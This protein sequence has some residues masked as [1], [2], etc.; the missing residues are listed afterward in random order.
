MNLIEEVAR[1][2]EFCGFGD[3]S[4]EH[5][6][7][8]IFWGHMPDKP[9]ECI[10]VFSS[11]SAYAGSEVGA[12]VQITTRGKTTKAA[13]ELSQAI[14]EEL[15]EFSGFLAGDGPHAKI[16]VENSSTGLGADNVRRELY[17]S[18]Y[19]IRYCET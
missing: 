5:T 2:L 12:R 7:G 13:Y 16:D 18:N 19:R 14:V 3:V 15:A 4:D 1:H 11:D 10:C 6:D 8:N 17:T 9:D